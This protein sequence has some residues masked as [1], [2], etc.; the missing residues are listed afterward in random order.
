M[1]KDAKYYERQIKGLLLIIGEEVHIDN[2]MLLGD[3]NTSMIARE[4][5]AEKLNMIL[6]DGINFHPEIIR[7]LDGEE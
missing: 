5:I 4:Y 1:E 2:R 3:D 6:D 7:N